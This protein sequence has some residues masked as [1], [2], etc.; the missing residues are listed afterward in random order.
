MLS[1]F[2]RLDPTGGA[3]DQLPYNLHSFAQHRLADKLAI[4]VSRIPVRLALLLHSK[5]DMA[6]S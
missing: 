4:K 2:R 5:L 1:E 3:N 6:N